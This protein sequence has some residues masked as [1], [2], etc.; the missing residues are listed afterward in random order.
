MFDFVDEE[1]IRMCAKDE[2]RREKEKGLR[3]T[4][5]QLLPDQ[6]CSK[7]STLDSSSNCLELNADTIASA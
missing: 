4:P 7:S 5:N 6:C 3:T 1:S 2:I